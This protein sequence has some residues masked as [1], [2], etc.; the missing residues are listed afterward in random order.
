MTAMPASVNATAAR[1]SRRITP[2]LR[3]HMGEYLGLKCP[4]CSE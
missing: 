2:L 4:E 1:S 3:A